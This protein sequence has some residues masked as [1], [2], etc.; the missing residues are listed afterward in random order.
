MSSS[1]V[2]TPYASQSLGY[3]CTQ[4][5][6]PPPSPPVDEAAKCSLPS[7]SSLLG[8]ADGGSP[9][10]SEQSQHSFKSEQSRTSFRHEQGPFLLSPREKRHQ[11]TFPAHQ[12][13]QHQPS[14][15]D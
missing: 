5:P 9:K 2:A 14:S 7:I 1:L 6:Q 3:L 8:L 11:L 4:P 10:P 13:N 15:T 12:P